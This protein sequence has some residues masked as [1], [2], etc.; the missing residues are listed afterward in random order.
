MLLKALLVAAMLGP[1][2]ADLS[3]S[4]ESEHFWNRYLASSSLPPAPS[5]LP[6]GSP[7]PYALPSLSLAPSALPSP[8]PAP[9]VVAYC[10]RNPDCLNCYRSSGCVYFPSDGICVCASSQCASDPIC[11]EDCVSDP[12]C[13][14]G[15]TGSCE[16]DDTS[17]TKTPP[18]A[19]TPTRF[20]SPRP[21]V[22]PRPRPRRL[23]QREAKA[24]E[25]VMGKS[26]LQ[27]VHI[28][29]PAPPVHPRTAVRSPMEQPRL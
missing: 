24:L 18:P 16:C 6:K 26:M 27:P 21:P 15:K 1:V 23:V 28:S 7:A 17:T 9:S 20:N 13:S 4:Q 10:G 25:N 11:A 12:L 22:R 19:R 29:R 5:A 14:L 2:I 3:E 8:S